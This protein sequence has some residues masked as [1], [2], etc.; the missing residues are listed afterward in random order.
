MTRSLDTQ[1]APPPERPDL[2]PL[3]GESQLTVLRR[4]ATEHSIVHGEVLFADGDK[5]YD[6]IVL[7]VGDVKIVD[8]YGRPDEIEI[9]TYG[10]REFIGEMSLLT[11]Q[12]AYL[13]AVAISDGRILSRTSQDDH[14]RRA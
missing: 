5:T 10:P 13:T 11:G 8:H 12:T 3:L 6:L 2:R 4:Y 1:I 14:V 7:L 9:I